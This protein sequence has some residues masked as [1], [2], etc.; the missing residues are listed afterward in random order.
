M[1]QRIRYEIVI[2]DIDKLCIFVE[3]DCKRRYFIIYSVGLN[4][5]TC[6]CIFFSFDNEAY[7]RIFV[8]NKFLFSPILLHYSI[9]SKSLISP[10]WSY[11]DEYF[12]LVHE[13]T[14]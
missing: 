8:A 2:I 12:T 9:V 1:V 5:F 13:N 4:T 10:V 3:I 11:V 7:A 6:R 14:C